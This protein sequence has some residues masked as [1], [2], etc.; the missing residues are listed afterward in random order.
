MLYG[1]RGSKA[2]LAT[3][4]GSGAST[5]AATV[6]VTQFGRRLLGKTTADPSD[7]RRNFSFLRHPQASLR[8]AASFSTGSQVRVCFMLHL[9][10]RKGDTLALR[11]LVWH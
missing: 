1:P 7:Q 6:T 4:D 10:I 3:A 5:G 9:G 2:R 8:A 11:Y